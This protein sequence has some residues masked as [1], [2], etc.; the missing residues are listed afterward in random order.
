MAL[1]ETTHCACLSLT[2]AVQVTTA[3]VFLSTE[4]TGTSVYKRRILYQRLD[5]QPS[6]SL[7][8]KDYATALHISLKGRGGSV[9]EIRT[10][11]REVQGSNPTTAV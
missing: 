8:H 9:V 10:P 3:E 2:P 4:R 5:G 6:L 7:A 1:I 11:E